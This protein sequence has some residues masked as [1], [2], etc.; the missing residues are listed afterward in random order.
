MQNTKN[1]NWVDTAELK[2]VKIDKNYGKKESYTSLVLAGVVAYFV[3]MI[4][5]TYLV[6]T[7][8]E[9]AIEMAK[10][11]LYQGNF[12]EVA[13]FAL[14]GVSLIVFGFLLWFSIKGMNKTK[15]GIIHQVNTKDNFSLNI[16]SIVISSIGIVLLIALTIF[17]IILFS[18]M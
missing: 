18:K 15:V 13:S 3:M 2:A 12:F 6:L 7:Y 4:I 14:S 17:R 9:I 10:D 1:I 11:L 16:F 5:T 8:G